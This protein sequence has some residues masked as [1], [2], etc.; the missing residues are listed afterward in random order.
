[1][2]GIL[3]PLNFF[4][5][6]RSRS[7]AELWQRWHMT[8]GRWGAHVHLPAPGGA[9]DP[10]RRHRD[11]GKWGAHTVSTLLPMFLSMLII[12]T[13]HGPNWTYVL[14][15]AMHGASCASTRSTIS[16]PAKPVARGPIPRRCWRCTL[17]LPSGLYARGSAL[18]LG[19]CANSDAH[20]R[21]NDRTERVR[22][23]AG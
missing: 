16:R 8:L 2:F 9:T 3:L 10:V 17:S 22:A 4:S 1:M 5:P 14:F 20:F 19:G 13:W 11:L 15:G 21:R 18:S 12:G 23:G 7:I 6:F